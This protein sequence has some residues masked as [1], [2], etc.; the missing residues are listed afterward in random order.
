MPRGRQKGGGT[1]TRTKID[2]EGKGWNIKTLSSVGF[3]VYS[4]LSYSPAQKRVGW[5]PG[6]EASGEKPR[7]WR[8]RSGAQKGERRWPRETKKE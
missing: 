8:K 6:D 5:R 7:N 2:T 4:L 1:Q 3:L